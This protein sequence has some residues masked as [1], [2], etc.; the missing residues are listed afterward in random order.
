[1]TSKIKLLFS[2]TLLLI[3]NSSFSLIG[4]LSENNGKIFFTE[5]ENTYQTTSSDIVISEIQTL[6]PFGTY[7]KLDSYIK[8]EDKRIIEVSETPIIISGNI[9]TSGKLI[10]DGQKLFL[11]NGKTKQL[12]KFAKA[13]NFRGNHFDEKSINFYINKNV[14]VIGIYKNKIFEITAIVQKGLYD[15]INTK[16]P[17]DPKYKDSLKDDP[18]NFILEELPKNQITQQINSFKTTILNKQ[19]IK[20][21]DH[22]LVISLAGR[23]GDDFNGVGGHFAIGT[24]V[25]DNNKIKDLKIFNFYTKNNGKGIIPGSLTYQDYYGGLSTGQ[26]NYRP[27]YTII[28]Y[29]VDEE[30]LK[31]ASEEIQKSLSYMR[32][33][34]DDGGLTNDCVNSSLDAL[35]SANIAEDDSIFSISK[36]YNG[37]SQPYDKSKYSA[38]NYIIYYLFHSNADFIP[39]A[40][41]ISML[42]RLENYDI[43]RAD[44][45][46]QQQTPSGRPEGG[47]PI[48]DGL[49]YIWAAHMEQER[50]NSAKENNLTGNAQYQVPWVASE[51][52]NADF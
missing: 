6:I 27:I 4:K 10:K 37:T 9:E 22:V 45:I 43:Y 39:R 34:N 24:G 35:Y 8:D 1:M 46:F 29:N 21:G 32:E 20:T 30:K 36:I 17:I 15:D 13:I 38:I 26:S 28:I 41:F 14:N 16:F 7:V 51:L 47:I 33:Y 2:C 49:D 50:V 5:G 18:F 25:I 12:V 3:S 52:Q 11:D 44:F 23:S 19:Q 31:K 42:E 48:K 40:A